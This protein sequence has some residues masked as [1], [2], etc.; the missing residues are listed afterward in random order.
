MAR[1]Q[2]LPVTPYG[3][4]QAGMAD[5][6]V[7]RTTGRYG[8]QQAGMADRQVWRTGRSWIAER[9]AIHASHMQELEVMEKGNN[10]ETRS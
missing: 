4:Q 3:G 5:R 9:Q 7:W 8:G 2:D 6:Q 10:Q 1:N